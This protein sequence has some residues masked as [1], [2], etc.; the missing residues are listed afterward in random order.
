M[1]ES[2]RRR[3]CLYLPG[4]CLHAVPVAPG[5]H[6]QLHVQHPRTPLSFKYYPLET[7]STLEPTPEQGEVLQY[8]ETLPS[9]YP[10]VHPALQRPSP[11]STP[12]RVDPLIHSLYTDVYPPVYPTFRGSLIR[13]FTPE[14][15]VETFSGSRLPL[16]KSLPKI[17][18]PFQRR[19]IPD[20]TPPNM[21][22]I[23]LDASTPGTTTPNFA[24]LGKLTI[25]DKAFENTSTSVAASQMRNALN[26][27]ADTVKDPEE[28]KVRIQCYRSRGIAADSL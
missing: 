7:R 18:R 21:P 28:K 1:N 16:P 12:E 5:R 8:I 24:A 17:R 19:P 22:A 2:G 27:L 15:P 4:L 9:L 25:Y 13:S 23:H 3:W 10:D 14:P 20:Y 6:E 26:Q 11:P